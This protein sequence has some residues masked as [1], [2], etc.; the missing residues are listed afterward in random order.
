MLQ[1]D[2]CGKLLALIR[3]H[4]NK[5]YCDNCKAWIGWA[6]KA[7][8]DDCIDCSIEHARHSKR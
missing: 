8:G 3:V 1:C 6:T 4:K 2:K 5:A 7:D